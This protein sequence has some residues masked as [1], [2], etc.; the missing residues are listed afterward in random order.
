[1][2]NVNCIISRY[3]RSA[4]GVWNHLNTKRDVLLL[5]LLNRV[6]WNASSRLRRSNASRATWKSVSTTMMTTQKEIRSP[7]YV[8]TYP[9]YVLKRPRLARKHWRTVYFGR[10]IGSVA[11]YFLRSPKRRNTWSIC[12]GWREPSIRWRTIANV[13]DWSNECPNELV[14]NKIGFIYLEQK[15]WRTIAWA[16]QS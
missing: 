6:G 12:V 1:M 15:Y 14:V 2:E 7:L 13:G 11:S 5:F 3:R 4:G 16:D 10:T 8:S 9:V